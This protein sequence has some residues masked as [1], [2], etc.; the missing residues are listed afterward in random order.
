MSQNKHVISFSVEYHNTIQMRIKEMKEEIM[1]MDRSILTVKTETEEINRMMMD[2]EIFQAVFSYVIKQKEAS[3]GLIKGM[4]MG[5]PDTK[6]ILTSNL[7]FLMFCL[8]C[9]VARKIGR[10][11]FLTKLYSSGIIEIMRTDRTARIMRLMA[12]HEISDIT[13]A[14]L[15]ECMISTEWSNNILIMPLVMFS[16]KM[17]SVTNKRIMARTSSDEL[18]CYYCLL[19][20]LMWGNKHEAESNRSSLFSESGMLGAGALFERT[21][22]D[23]MMNKLTYSINTEMVFMRIECDMSEFNYRMDIT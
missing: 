16:G 1:K 14:K 18:Y 20:S 23:V 7:R 21:D 3:E 5:N 10:E 8:D 12:K 11:K 6:S 15:S 9:G 2:V 19:I 4:I 22:M 17:V 13:S